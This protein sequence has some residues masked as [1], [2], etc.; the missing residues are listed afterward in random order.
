MILVVL[1]PYFRHLKEFRIK[2]VG[3]PVSGCSANERHHDKTNK[4]AYV[5][6]EDADQPRHLS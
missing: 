6:V 2:V 1:K 4:I 5:P 3:N